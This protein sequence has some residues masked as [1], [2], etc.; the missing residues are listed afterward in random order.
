MTLLLKGGMVLDGDGGPPRRADVAIDGPRI[1]AVAEDLI[2]ADAEVRDVS[3]LIVAPGFIDT[4]THDDGAILVDPR[5]VPKTSQGVTTVVVG[6]CGIGLAPVSRARVEGLGLPALAGAAGTFASFADYLAAVAAAKP[7]VNVVPLVGHTTLRQ[8]VM[9]DSGRAATATEIAGMA[10]I[11]DAAMRAGAAGL[12]TGLY[13]GAAKSASTAEVVALAMVAATHGG[14]YATHLRDEGND[15]TEAMDEAFAIGRAAGIPVLL[16]HH[17]VAG[18]ANW[19]RAQETLAMIAAA[20]RDQPVMLDVYPYA[21]SSTALIPERCD[22]SVAVRVSW[23]AP[24]PEMNGRD[25]GEIAAA[26]GCTMRE[27]AERLLPGGAI[28]FTMDEADVR[29]VLASPDAMIGSD[30]M[31]CD[32][33]PHPR[34]WG[35]FPRVLGHYARDAGLFSL[36]EAVRRM[37]ALAADAFGL[38][39]RGRIKPGAFADVTVFDA[40]AIGSRASFD[41]PRVAADGIHLVLVNGQ[42]AWADGAPG[43]GGGG[44]IL[45]RDKEV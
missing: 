7:A 36:A 10:T 26:W 33:H 25:I 40:A 35:T 45:R 16:S 31:P 20:R 30:G 9:G 38:A 43:P 42:T 32:A 4:H 34:L 2:F 19:G 3:G 28:Y 37:T 22:G 5:L 29:A 15:V 1:V 17:K 13:Y 23:S 41:D 44:R 12:S 8:E 14:L 6:N 11:L 39:G 21:A 27:A 24:H 18:R